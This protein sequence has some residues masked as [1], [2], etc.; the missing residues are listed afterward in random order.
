VFSLLTAKYVSLRLPV[1]PK[2]L[3]PPAAPVLTRRPAQSRSSSYRQSG[4]D[5]SKQ[6]ASGEKG[7]PRGT[8]PCARGTLPGQWPASQMTG[9][10]GSKDVEGG[11]FQGGRVGAGPGE[12]HKQSVRVDGPSRNFKA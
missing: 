5:R 11:G 1:G 10:E 2:C 9:P 6:T 8:L 4:L 7:C 12:Q 3:A